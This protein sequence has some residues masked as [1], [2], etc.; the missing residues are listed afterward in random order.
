MPT[1]IRNISL[2]RR[3]IKIHST[4]RLQGSYK[5]LRQ[6]IARFASVSPDAISISQ[7]LNRYMML[8]AMRMRDIKV[9]V[10]KTGTSVKLD[11]SPELKPKKAVADA[12]GQKDSNQAKNAKKPAEQK[13]EGR[14]PGKSEKGTKEGST[15]QPRPQNQK[16][17]P[18]SKNQQNGKNKGK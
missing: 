13:Q 2:R 6:E 9:S 5:Y 4:R 11:L 1:E 8:N 12:A 15:L 14:S 3:L 17:N 10:E 18:E 16:A 7:D